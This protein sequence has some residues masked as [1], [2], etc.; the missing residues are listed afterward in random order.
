MVTA[1]AEHSDPENTYA[2]ELP[3]QRPSTI[4]GKGGTK[5]S[6]TL[7]S[8]FKN[9]WAF[10]RSWVDH[11][12]LEHIILGKL[13]IWQVVF[14]TQHPTTSEIAREMQEESITNGT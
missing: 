7:E 5:I 1:L 8:H 4:Y 12:T 13:D 14:E 6:T 11:F 10:I 3:E 2:F 9:N